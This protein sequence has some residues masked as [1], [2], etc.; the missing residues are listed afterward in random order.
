[1]DSQSQGAGGLRTI[2]IDHLKD[3]TILSTSPELGTALG[4]E[5]V[6][7]TSLFSFVLPEDTISLMS[8]RIVLLL[9]EPGSHLLF[10]PRQAHSQVVL[11]MAD[12]PTD[13]KVAFRI[14]FPNAAPVPYIGRLS[15]LSAFPAPRRT[16][17]SLVLL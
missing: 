7:G 4:I 3:G 17:F 6:P 9:S 2:S 14:R 5:K 10:P 11:S 15:V 16:F 8:V 13:H 1:M 12:A